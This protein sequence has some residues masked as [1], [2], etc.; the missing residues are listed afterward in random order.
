MANASSLAPD[1]HP[2]KEEL[3][4]SGDRNFAI[5][6]QITMLVL[7]LLFPL[8]LLFILYFICAKRLRDALKVRQSELVSPG[9]VSVSADFKRQIRDGYLMHQSVES[10]RTQQPV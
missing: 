1:F 2:R 6:G 4:V 9:N 5:N 7:L 3:P 10:K 8:C